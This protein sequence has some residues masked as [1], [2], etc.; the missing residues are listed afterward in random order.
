MRARLGHPLVACV[1]ALWLIAD[2][3]DLRRFRSHSTVGEVVWVLMGRDRPNPGS[4]LNV[5]GKRVG[6][7][8]EL[9]VRE[10]A[11]SDEMSPVWSDPDG[12]IISLHEERSWHGFWAPISRLHRTYLVV[13]PT[14]LGAALPLELSALQM[15]N[16]KS[17]LAAWLAANSY[18]A[19][20]GAMVRAAPSETREYFWLN[21]VRNTVAALVC[22]LMLLSVVNVRTWWRANR[23][24]RRAKLLVRGVCPACG[25]GMLDAARCPECGVERN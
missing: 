15:Q 22:V 11:S 1:C 5:L 6:N 24:A 21:I 2:A 12:V 8:F 17:E 23:A 4:P 3:A 16:L 25:Y 14:T 13:T 20:V 10:G 9:P 7:S 19:E 18:P